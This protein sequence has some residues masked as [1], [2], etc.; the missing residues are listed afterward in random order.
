MVYF[1]NKKIKKNLEVF[2]KEEKKE[3]VK[4]PNKSIAFTSAIAISRNY[5]KIYIK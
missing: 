3:M 2:F 5:I 1:T 4:L